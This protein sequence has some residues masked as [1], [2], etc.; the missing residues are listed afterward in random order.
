MRLR[1]TVI[2]KLV[3]SP[4]MCGEHPRVLVGEGGRVGRVVHGVRRSSVLFSRFSYYSFL[5]TRLI[6]LTY[7]WSV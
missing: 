3:P 4:P 1:L 7:V 5:F 2:S 6:R